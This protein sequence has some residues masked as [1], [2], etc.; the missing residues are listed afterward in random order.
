[1]RN[2]IPKHTIQTIKP[3]SYPLTN[4]PE[5]SNSIIQIPRNATK[6]HDPIESNNKHD[7]SIILCVLSFMIIQ[8]SVR[9]NRAAQRLMQRNEQFAISATNKSERI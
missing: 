9:V 2:Y 6:Q 1:M 3:L 5:I 7:L 8:A 4:F